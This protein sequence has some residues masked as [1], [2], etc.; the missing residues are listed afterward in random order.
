M[1]DSNSMFAAKQLSAA[2]LNN[3]E[4]KI[5]EKIKNTIESKYRIQ[6]KKFEDI[7]DNTANGIVGKLQDKFVG[8][9]EKN[10]DEKL[11]QFYDQVSN[12]TSIDLIDKII[13]EVGLKFNEALDERWDNDNIT[14]YSNYIKYF[15]G[16]QEDAINK[17][18]VTV[19]EGATAKPDVTAKPEVTAKSEVTAQ[20]KVT[21]GGRKTKRNHKRNKQSNTK[22]KRNKQS[23]TKRKRK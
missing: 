9:I 6:Q 18:K 11:A 7:V 16:L 10:F 20:T 4:E 15:K 12:E 22:R 5:C 21:K 17:G 1:N 2:Q 19:N 8:I 13:A 3:I 23:N 14:N